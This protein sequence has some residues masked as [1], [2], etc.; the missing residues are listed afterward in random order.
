[1]LVNEEDNTMSKK[2]YTLLSILLL[3]LTGCQSEES[4][5]ADV[6]PSVKEVDGKIEVD[7]ED[8]TKEQDLSTEKWTLNIFITKEIEDRVYEAYDDERSYQLFP[9]EELSEAERRLLSEG[10]S[11]V[12]QAEPFTILDGTSEQ[13]LDPEDVKIDSIPVTVYKVDV[14]DDSTKAVFVPKCE[15]AVLE[16]NELFASNAKKDWTMIDCVYV[17]DFAYDCVGVVLFKDGISDYIKIAYMDSDGHMQQCG[18]EMFP[19]QDPELTYHGK[20]TVTFNTCS[21]NEEAK[22]LKITFSRNDETVNFV[23]EQNTDRDM[24]TYIESIKEQ[25]DTI[26]ASLEN[27]PLTQA[28]MN[29]KS[30]E[31]YELWDGALNYLWGEVKILSLEEEFEKLLD[32]QRAW[33]TKKEEKA[34]EAGKDVEGGSLYPLVVNG[35]VARI[36]E[37][38]VY[39]LYDLY[40][41]LRLR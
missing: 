7:S 8:S 5:I 19:A 21:E 33:I 25:S 26:R 11:L 30:Q 2:I 3:S 28:E 24:D 23:V 41:V 34:A 36:T 10:A 27:D 18:V 35:E 32:E 39:M 40:D 13:I 31:L 37:E 1:M 38:R 15:K 22:A 9:S 20:G 14:M 12:I 16:I 4:S 6:V 17:Y 29:V